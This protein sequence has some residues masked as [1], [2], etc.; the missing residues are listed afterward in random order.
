MKYPIK[1]SSELSTKDITCFT[2][3]NRNIPENFAYV[4]INN[5]L[6]DIT[7]VLMFTESWHTDQLSFLSQFDFTEISEYIRYGS[8]TSY[9]AYQACHLIS[10]AKLKGEFE[11]LN[12]FF[13]HDMIKLD[14]KYSNISISTDFSNQDIV[15][16]AN[17]LYA[18]K[19][20]L[21]RLLVLDDN[22]ILKDNIVTI[23]K[24]RST[25]S[26]FDLTYFKNL[27]HYIH[28]YQLPH[29][30]DRANKFKTEVE[31][32]G[33]Y[34]KK[35]QKDRSGIRVGF[36]FININIGHYNITIS[37]FGVPTE[38]SISNLPYDYVNNIRLN[39]LFNFMI[40][41]PDYKKYLTNLEMQILKN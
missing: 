36:K 7:E 30:P 8:V 27:S 5:V 4:F 6:S 24:F 23:S 19:A 41:H 2:C 13:N 15:K 34:Y 20:K 33:S 32:L 28:K 22:Q 14:L 18:F 17:I 25:T 9:D 11:N 3:Y 26:E 16:D 21:Q 12:M 1:Q 31:E 10:I 40:S 38:L 29:F 35:I 37:A 39:Y